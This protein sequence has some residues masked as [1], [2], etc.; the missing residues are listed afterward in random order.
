MKGKVEIILMVLLLVIPFADVEGYQNKSLGWGYKKSTNEHLP[1]VGSYGPLLEKFG[2]Y[3]MDP[4]GDKVVYLTFDN[5]YEQGFTGKVLDVLKN[6]KVS[7]TFFV[8]GHYIRS[9]EDLIQRMVN[10]GHI[11]GNHS[12]SHPD[13]TKLSKEKMKEELNKVDNTVAKLT[14]QKTM[15]YLR[16]PR[17]VFSERSLALTQELG[18]TNVFWSIAFVD[19]N[20]NAQRG[21]EYAYKSIIN[22]VHPGAIILLHAV[23]KDNAEAL[24]HIIDE[25]RKRGYTFESLDDL[26]VKQILPAPIM[27]YIGI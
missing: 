2:A 27:K 7:A 3:Y 22:Q 6:K 20:T 25:L 9:S 26:M 13:F 14:D 19:W 5:G 8:T 16:P 12:W 10:E 24:E 17:G 15:N 4:T 11:I 1:E 18:Y 23:S 21:W